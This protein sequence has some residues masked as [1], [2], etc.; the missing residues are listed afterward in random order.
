MASTARWRVASA[1]R[2]C[3]TQRKASKASAAGPKSAQ[4]R[5]AE[6]RER[7]GTAHTAH[8]KRVG[9]RDA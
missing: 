2:N 7:A 6:D 9:E 4:K 8:A 1:L 5:A 3:A